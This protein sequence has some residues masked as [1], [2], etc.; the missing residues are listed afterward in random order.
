MGVGRSGGLE[1]FG[2]DGDNDVWGAWSGGG[3]R[4]ELMI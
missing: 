1:S 2:Y 3:F 4:F